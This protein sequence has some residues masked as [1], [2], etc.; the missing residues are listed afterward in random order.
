MIVL[1]AFRELLPKSIEDF[2]RLRPAHVSVSS[3]HV[4]GKEE[5]ISCEHAMHFIEQCFQLDKMMQRLIGHDNVILPLRR[6]GIDVGPC[7]ADSLE[8]PLLVS[9]LTAALQ[10][11]R[12][13]VEALQDKVRN[14]FASQRFNQRDFCVAIPGTTTDEP[15]SGFLM[16]TD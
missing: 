11:M 16:V 7:E 9:E 12:I 5:P 1:V 13:N 15:H 4:I 2:Q 8:Y 6:P 3:D 14:A 10:H